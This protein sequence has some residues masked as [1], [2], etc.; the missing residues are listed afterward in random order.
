MALWEKE[1]PYFSHIFMLRCL[2]SNFLNSCPHKIE[3]LEQ[4][5]DFWLHSKYGFI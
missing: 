3:V 2:I 1:M 4:F 5:I